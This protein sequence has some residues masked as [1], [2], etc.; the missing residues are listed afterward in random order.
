MA[1]LTVTGLTVQRGG[2]VILDR[3]RWQV[4]SGEHWAIL[5]ANGSGK[6]SL[7]SALTGYLTPTDGEVEL[8]SHRYGAA[9]WRELRKRVGLVSSTVRQKIPED[10]PALE[11]VISGRQAMIGF[12]G[13]IT[14]SDRK[15]GLA[16]LKDIGCADL[17]D[18]PW[19]YLSQG[20]R[21]RLLIGRALM[22]RPALLILDEPCSGL[23]PVAR[24]QFLQFLQNLGHSPKPPAMV[25]VTHH[26]EEIIPVFSHVLVLRQGRVLAA[27]ERRKTL[28]SPILSRAFNADIRL[29]R[30]ND[31]YRIEIRR[32]SKKPM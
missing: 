10:E 32:K 28:T 26:T 19:L 22:A 4:M 2:S 21:Q 20:E 8:L 7:L 29:T 18:R 11:T 16:I 14:A 31:R 13:R 17:A 23:D 25:L 27:G 24:E 9:D 3:I 12:W 6:T 1:I 5:G 15:R 30:R